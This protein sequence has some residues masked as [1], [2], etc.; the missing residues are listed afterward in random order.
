MT[1][2]YEPLPLGVMRIFSVRPKTA[3]KY[4][5]DD[6]D[7]LYKPIFTDNNTVLK[8]Y[9]MI[10]KY[11]I[12]YKDDEQKKIP[13]PILNVACHA[14]SIRNETRQA[15]TTEGRVSRHDD[16]KTNSRVIKLHKVTTPDQNTQN[17]MYRTGLYWMF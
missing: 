17:T 1:L 7:R 13:R 15:I 12:K 5:D 4:L 2:I 3:K 8:I 16:P 10:N 6:N 9:S 11:Y 14:E